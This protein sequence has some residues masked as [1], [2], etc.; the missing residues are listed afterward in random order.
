MQIDRQT[1]ERELAAVR[2]QVMQAHLVIQ[3]APG[4]ERALL[5]MLSILAKEEPAAEPA[6]EEGAS[7]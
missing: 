7:Q 5:A 3:Q 2:A 4:A 6:A 1:V